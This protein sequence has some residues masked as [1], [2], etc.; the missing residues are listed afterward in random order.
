MAASISSDECAALLSQVLYKCKRCGEPYHEIDNLGA[1]NCVQPVFQYMTPRLGD[2][3]L[4]NA[5]HKRKIYIAADH[6]SDRDADVVYGPADDL[7]FNRSN[8]GP[9]QA[10]VLHSH[11]VIR[12]S[13]AG[14]EMF[15]GR[16]SPLLPSLNGALFAVRRYDHNALT[17]ATSD[18][19]LAL[20]K[21]D[22]PKHPSLKMTLRYM[23]NAL[24]SIHML[25]VMQDPEHLQERAEWL[26][27]LHDIVRF[28]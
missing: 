28:N 1:W 3:P 10:G 4:P 21:T 19:E 16:L 14:R 15:G 23:Q 25:F 8:I 12:V 27:T 26:A 7:V 17:L 5:V 13:L 24:G 2:R 6:I 22:I 20:G 11:S 18:F 9:F